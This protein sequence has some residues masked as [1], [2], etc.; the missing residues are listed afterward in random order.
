MW[1]A[2]AVTTCGTGLI[3]H[4]Y[5]IPSEGMLLEI[6]RDGPILFTPSVALSPCAMDGSR[7]TKSSILYTYSPQGSPHLYIIKYFGRDCRPQT[8]NVSPYVQDTLV[9]PSDQGESLLTLAWARVQGRERMEGGKPCWPLHCWPE[10]GF[11]STSPTQ[12]IT[13]YQLWSTWH[14]LFPL[15]SRRTCLQSYSITS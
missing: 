15:L 13:P 12:S 10:A 3:F 9:L 14:I 7:I 5:G 4:L 6:W 8:L 1:G 2:K 11:P